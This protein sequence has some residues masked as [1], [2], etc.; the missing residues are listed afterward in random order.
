VT[1]QD[2]RADVAFD[3]A[4]G[5]RKS[6]GTIAIAGN[7][8]TKKKTIAQALTFGKGDFVSNQASS[9]PSSSSTGRGCS[10]TSS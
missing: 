3:I 5:D 9:R 6:V 4:A 1:L 8:V 2:E 10:R 7:L